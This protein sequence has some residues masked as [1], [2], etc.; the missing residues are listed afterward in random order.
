MGTIGLITV[1]VVGILLFLAGCVVMFMALDSI[2]PNSKRENIIF[3]ILILSLFGLSF[4]CLNN[5]YQHLSIHL[6]P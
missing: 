5:A 3:T 2:S 4:L 1:I 6:I